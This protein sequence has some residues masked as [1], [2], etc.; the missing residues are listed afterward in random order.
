MPLCRSL[1][2][3]GNR[4][5]LQFLRLKQTD[6]FPNFA[7]KAI[8]ITHCSVSNGRQQWVKIGVQLQVNKK[9]GFTSIEQKNGKYPVDSCLAVLYLKHTY[10][11]VRSQSPWSLLTYIESIAANVWL[12]LTTDPFA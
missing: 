6:I 10:C 1:C 7:F 11:R 12:N 3:L 4:Y 5:A 2:Y 9:S 8:C